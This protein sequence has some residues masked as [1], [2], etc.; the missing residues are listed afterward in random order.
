MFRAS[1]RFLPAIT[2]MGVIYR[3][4]DTPGLKS[5]PVAQRLGLLPGS[6]SAQSAYWL[7]W[8]LRK[9]AHLASFALLALLLAW[10]LGALLDRRRALWLAL[11]LTLLYAISDEVHQ[12]FVP[13]RQGRWWDVL[14]D[15]AGAALALGWLRTRRW[16][17]R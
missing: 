16:T 13:G 17:T 11:G 14:I 4:S 9:S 8:I 6:L 2:W 5:V 3:F 12:T 1:L 7:E 10:A 15:T